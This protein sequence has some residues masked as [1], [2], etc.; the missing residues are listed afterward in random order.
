[1]GNDRPNETEQPKVL[2]AEHIDDMSEATSLLLKEGRIEDAV[3]ELAQ[4]RPADRAEVIASLDHDLQW[5]I[6]RAL[7]P[8]VVV[9]L[10]EALD[11]EAAVT[12][13][14]DLTP[15]QLSKVLDQAGLDVAADVLRALDDQMASETMHHMEGS[16]QVASLMEF[17]DDQAGGLMVPVAISLRADMTVAEAVAYI[18]DSAE[19]VDPEDISHIFVVDDNDV[20]NGLVGVAQLLLAEPDEKLSNVMHSDVIHVTPEVDQEECARIMRRYDIHHLPVVDE[21][22]RL[23]GVLSSVDILDVLEEEATEDM[24][25]MVGVQEEEETSG[26][27]WRSITSRLPWLYVYMATAML[28]AVIVGLFESTITRVVTLA[29]FLNVVPGQGG[30]GGVQTVTLVVRSM[31]LGELPSSRAWRLITREVVL[32]VIEGVMLGIAVGIVAYVWKGNYML[33]VV[34]AV[35]MIGNMLIGALTG[36]GIPLVLRRLRIDPAVSSAVFVTTFTDV[37][38]VLLFLGLATLLVDLL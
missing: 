12:L 1:M 14:H 30:Q 32:G 25:K 3:V 38:G 35:A 26:P 2:Q 10:I 16:E 9:E 4:L 8:D 36:A 27:I 33:G 15:Q 11:P 29:I 37:M 34:L 13:A 31:A 20:L 28:S 24:L 7:E 23:R 5:R 6:V 21:E 18:L 22:A 17:D 19:D